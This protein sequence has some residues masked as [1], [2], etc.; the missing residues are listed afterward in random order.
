MTA[1]TDSAE[2]WL[3]LG[4][5]LR[6]QQRWNEAADAF[7]QSLA[8]DPT[9]ATAWFLLGLTEVNANRY[10][11]A[12][13]AYQQSLKLAPGSVETLTCYAFL[14]NQRGQPQRAIELLHEVLARAGHIAVAWLVL[15]HACELIGDMEAA[16][17][18]A[19]QAVALAPQDPAARYQLANVLLF[20]WQ[21]PSEALDQIRQLL[22][23]QPNHADGWSLHGLI[24]R[25][26]GRHDE[27]I[28][29]LRRAVELSPTPQNHSKLLAGL[30]YSSG[31]TPEA[32]L[33]A[34]H[35][36]NSNHAPQSAV[37]NSRS[38]SS[39]RSGPLRIGILSADF[40]QHPTGFMILPA[41][42]HLDHQ[43][44]SVVCYA[45]RITEDAYTNRFRAV[46]ETWH[47]TLGMP[48]DDLVEIIRRDNIDILF[49]M[50]GHFGERMSLFTKRPA[51]IQITWFG[52]VGTTGLPAI[53]YLLA[54]AHHVRPGEEQ[55]YTEVV[56]RMPNGYACY[57]PPPDAPE[58][59][60]LPALTTGHVTFGCFNNPAKFTGSMFDAWAEILRRVP[61]AR[62]MFKF[63]WLGEPESKNRLHAEFAQRGVPEDR[64]IIETLSP[65]LELLAAYG[66]IDLAL[67]TQPYSGGLTTCEAL[68]MGVPV[69]TFPGKTFA[70]RH[71]TS[72]LTNA[73][74]PQFIAADQAE[75][76]EL[77]VGWA[78]RLAELANIRAQMR[79]QVLRSPLCDAPRFASD[80]L[81]LLSSLS[82]QA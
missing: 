15:G 18:A 26:L 24:L 68:W 64:L 80:F 37:R 11:N 13:Q 44:C 1:P 2:H 7:R 52:Y 46:A 51:P 34:H 61:T 45:D 69:I 38:A 48:H 75:Y 63:G 71:S 35:E 58:V 72:H 55:W 16:E 74:Y 76:I 81:T 14:L 70:G 36:W 21:H 22:A 25:A 28:T 50:S 27:S 17:K 60:P 42:E 56:L 6:A 47:T 19:R 10:D 41:L 78:G 9:S 40:G 65:H 43:R 79:E 29:A 82:R 23:L 59:T 66:R 73:G 8:R 30:Q 49:D 12:E 62:M 57:G 4:N 33:R 54:D 67:D 20:R 53:D 39:P 5:A 32:L 3:Q 77:A 31:I